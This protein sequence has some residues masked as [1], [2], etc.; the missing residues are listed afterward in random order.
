MKNFYYF[1]SRKLKFVEIKLFNVKLISTISAF[2]MILSLLA[3]GAYIKF[4]KRTDIEYLRNE[5]QKLVAGL[6]QMLNKYDDL[7]YRAGTILKAGNSLRLAVNLD[8]FSEEDQKIGI[9]GKAFK[10]LVPLSSVE[11]EGIVEKLSSKYDE[12][13]A[14]IN[15]QKLS[16]NE[17]ES[18]LEVDKKAFKYLPALMPVDADMG[19]GFGMRYHPI[20]KIKRMHHGQDFKCNTG[21]K[22]YATADGKVSFAGR[23]GG[24]GRTVEI[25][26]GNG[27]KTLFGHLY[28]FKVKV[29]DKVKRGDLVAISGNSGSLSTGPHLHYEVKYNGV[30][31]NPFD[32]FYADLKPE[33]YNKLKKE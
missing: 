29:G 21:A 1:S 32:Y 19:D 12:L 5:N 4:T 13:S 27:Y 23:R 2:S 18:K 15:F 25:D 11:S 26:H 22:V 28:K 10:E 30:T 17:V 14:K 8:Q 9:G 31:Q 6:N 3:L 24:Y 7:E 33:D 16:I 20:L